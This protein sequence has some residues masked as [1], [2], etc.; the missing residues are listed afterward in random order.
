MRILHT[1]DWHLGQRFL[2]NDRTEEQR[3]ALD[4]LLQ[5]IAEE[6]VEI[7][8]I[9]GDIFDLGN[10]PFG[11]R[12]LYYQFLTRLQGTSC[13]H[14]VIIAGNHDAPGMLEAPK[15]LL[16]S[17]NIH[18]V[19]AAPDNKEEIMLLLYHPD[20]RLEAIVAAVPFLRDRDLKFSQA[21]ESGSERIERLKEALTGYFQEMGALSAPF[22][23]SG[24]PVIAMGHLYAAGAE[25]SDKQDNI[26]IGDVENIRA[27]AF[28]AEFSYVALGHIH[29]PQAVGGIPRVRY[30]GSL[31][32]LSFSE[33]KDEK[34]VYLLDYSGSSLESIRFIPIP[35][36]RRLKTIEGTLEEVR[37][38]LTRFAAQP[39]EGLQPWVEVL[40]RSD[41]ILPG[42]DA[43]LQEY[44]TGM[45]LDLLKIRVEYG[46]HQS[47]YAKTEEE[48]LASLEPLEVFR[49]RCMV[50]GNAP[51]N[52]QELEQTFRE[53]QAWMAEYEDEMEE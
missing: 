17:L 12:R 2:Q 5:L 28:P 47:L 40:V 48:E 50:A 33:T 14:A 44:C 8:L 20:G 6:N 30:S 27:D 34:G 9:A 36:Q 35:L 29:R 52:L 19:G 31:I 32:P 4:A 26:Y 45:D 38:K 41:A 37:Q 22:A 7:L 13:R 53:L 21:G 11:A 23:G 25:A 42:L 16:K 18:V 39:R 24:V 46:S 15:E 10:P 3:L 43:L 49:R 51:E 1:S